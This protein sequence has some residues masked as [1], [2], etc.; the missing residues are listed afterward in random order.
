MFDTNI[1]I[2]TSI[3]KEA[4]GLTDNQW[5]HFRQLGDTDENMAAILPGKPE[6]TGKARLFSPMRA[7][8]VCI[9]ADFVAV[10]VKAPLAAKIARKIMEAHQ[11]EPGV[12]Q[13]AII[14][15]ANGNVSTLPY[16]QTDLQ[17]GFISG[18]RLR[19]AVVVDLQNYADQ[20]ATAIASAPK[21]IGGGDAE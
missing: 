19:F 20:V 9:A 14:V 6:V 5:T 10:D 7:V 15:T 8:L 1:L 16:Q 13:W 4:S 21:V 12:Q 17:T 11:R 3:V 18:S 2:P